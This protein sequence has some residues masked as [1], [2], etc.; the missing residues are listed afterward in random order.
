VNVEPRMPHRRPALL[1]VS[2]ELVGP[3]RAVCRARVHGDHPMTRGGAARS[4]LAL[5]LVAQAAAFLRDAA[6]EGGAPRL[7]GCRELVLHVAELRE[8]EELVVTVE[9]QGGGDDGS[10]FVGRVERPSG[11]RVADARFV[12]RRTW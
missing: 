12:V 11:E 5:E 2:G 6:H 8:G 4:V 10:T 7:V 1:L 3:E 9:R